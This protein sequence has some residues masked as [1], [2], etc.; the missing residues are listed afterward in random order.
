M[1]AP[2]S[3][4]PFGDIMNV[5]QAL[6]ISMM[7]VPTRLRPSPSARWTR[8][9][10]FPPAVV[11]GVEEEGLGEKQQH[12][13]EEGRGEHAHHVVRELRVENDEHERQSCSEGRGEREG[14]RKQLGELVRELVVSQI[15]GLVA[16]HLDDEREDR[17]GKD[18]GREQQ[19]EL[20][21]RPDGDAAADDGDGTILGLR[22]RR[23]LGL[24]CP[25]LLPRRSIP[26]FAVS[27]RRPRPE[28]GKDPGTRGSSGT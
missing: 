11:I 14:D 17:Y 22:V 13:R 19:M 28:R 27:D 1:T 2:V 6:A 12:V 24:R 21:N 26:A 18:E 9:W 16:D 15:A 4:T 20:R 8:G 23:C 25:Q 10:N 3:E 5:T 7:A